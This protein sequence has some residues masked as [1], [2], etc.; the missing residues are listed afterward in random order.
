MNEYR[1]TKPV[2]IENAQLIWRNFSGKA[3]KFNAEGQR[4]FNVIIDEDTYAVLA[5]DGWNV[6]V[7]MPKEDQDPD[8]PPLYILPV[9][10]AFGNKPP[11]IKLI[12]STGAKD[13]N[14]ETVG[15]LDFIDIKTCDVV[16]NPYNYNVMG[17]S[18]VSGYLKAL[19]VTMVED[20]FA[21]KYV[22]VPTSA[23]GAIMGE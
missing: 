6:R 23:V 7:I 15:M 21:G 17:R 11:K 20:R 12:S 3:G 13:L 14:E 22:D 4:N 2:E 5:N 18:G 8:T 19:Y 10:V 9:K 1:V 16:V